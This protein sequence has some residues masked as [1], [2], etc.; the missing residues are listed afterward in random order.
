[1]PQIVPD[2]LSSL[3]LTPPS[4]GWRPGQQSLS[5]QIAQSKKKIV[6]LEA[7]CGTGKSIIPIAAATADQK[8]AVVLIQTINL[9]EQYLRDIKGLAMMTGRAH[10]ECNLTLGPASEAPCTVGA[11]CDLKGIWSKRGQPLG[12]PDCHYFKRKAVAAL[13]DVSIQNYAYWLGE[14][15]GP[16]SSF[17]QR[18][19]VVCDEG[20]EL[21]QILMASAVIE[22]RAEDL[23]Q[24]K[25]DLLKTIGSMT[26]ADLRTWADGPARKKIRAYH[27]ALVDQ[28]HKL[29]ID[30]EEDNALTA[31]GNISNRSAYNLLIK[32]LQVHQRLEQAVKLLSKIRDDELDEWVVCP[33]D[34]TNKEWTVRP[35]YGK[36]GFRRVIECAKEKVV[37]MSAYLAPEL[38]MKNLGLEP[39]EVD[40]IIAP[41]VFNR[42]RSPILYT[43]VAKVKYGMSLGQKKYY[44]AM[45]DAIIDN[46]PTRGLLHVPSVAMRD[47][48]MQFSRHRK[49]LIAYDGAG[50][51]WGQQNRYPAKDEAIAQFIAREGSILLGQSISTGLDLPNIPQWQIITKLSFPPTNDPVISAR[52]KL[53]K[54]FYHYHTICQLVQATGRV[55][56]SQDHNGPTIIMDEQFGWFY[57]ANAKYFPLWFRENLKLRNGWDY[58]KEVH[59]QRNKIAMHAGISLT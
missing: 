37:I 51:T 52:M 32:G 42:V 40:V 20:H 23:R 5:E 36:Y 59:A 31:G 44:Y 35:V 55:K 17:N 58:L 30:L 10:S 49:R 3:G 48:I 56:R 54:F 41:K 45:M 46:Y 13:A 24:A 6:M 39:E 7:E 38:L 34:R 50:S 25:F 21:D 53:D 8:K 33:P 9:Q 15:S 14:S 4:W 28:A 18:D 19:W 2:D 29:G 57:A 1:M 26:P 22:L 12:T 47:E 11:K 43:P 27:D 16:L